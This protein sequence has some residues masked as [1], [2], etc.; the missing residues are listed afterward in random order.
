MNRKTY[1]L[2]PAAALIGMASAYPAAGGPAPDGAQ[3]FQQRC[4]A[5]HTV[6]PGARTTL[7]PNLAG[8]LNRKAASTAFNYSPALKASNL[9]WTRANLDRYLTGPGQMVPGTRMVISIS[10]PAQR[11]AVLNYITTR[12]AR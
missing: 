9:T 1:L 2:A 11:A 6:V 12:P 3:L 10:N 4:A 5:C 7:A 8:L